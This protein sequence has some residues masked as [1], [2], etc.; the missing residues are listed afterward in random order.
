MGNSN[1]VPQVTSGGK[2]L[3]FVFCIALGCES[4]RRKPLVVQS[5]SLDSFS[6]R[7]SVRGVRPGPECTF[8]GM[9][10]TR[11]MRNLLTVLA[12]MHALTQILHHFI[13]TSSRTGASQGGQARVREPMRLAVQAWSHK[14][15]APAPLVS[16]TS[17]FPPTC[18]CVCP[19][20]AMPTVVV[21]CISQSIPHG[22]GFAIELVVPLTAGVLSTTFTS[23]ILRIPAATSPKA[24]SICEVPP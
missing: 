17:I 2:A 19:I 10:G 3:P 12:R 14:H 15:L 16:T 21:S 4:D 24:L 1:S 22:V 20:T 6:V 9:R 13:V 18:L 11:W 8:T 7:F 5:S 23:I